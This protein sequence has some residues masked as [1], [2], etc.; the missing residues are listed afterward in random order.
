MWTIFL[1]YFGLLILWIS[2]GQQFSFYLSY[3]FVILLPPAIHNAIYY[4]SFTNQCTALIMSEYILDW[5]LLSYHNIR[6]IFIF[7]FR[8]IPFIILVY[9]LL[10]SVIS[11][12]LSID[13][14]IRKEWNIVD[15]PYY[16]LKKNILNFMY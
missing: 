3:I 1:L 4:L 13:K 16:N 14:K 7:C 11:T 2:R 12:Y 8:S 5:G 10:L 6:T 9:G 15:V